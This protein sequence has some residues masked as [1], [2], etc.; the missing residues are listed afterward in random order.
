LAEKGTAQ[1]APDPFEEILERYGSLLRGTIAQVCPRDL[2]LQFD[3]IEQEARLRI[4]RTLKSETRIEKPASY[5]YRVA[6]TATLDAVRRAT[7]RREEQ[8]PPSSAGPDATARIEGQAPAGPPESPES[9]AHHRLL[10]DK[11]QAVLRGMRPDRRAAVSLHIRGFVP[12]EIGGLLRWSE[13]RA[14][15]AVYR[16][17]KE[18]RA[19]LAAEGIE[20]ES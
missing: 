1:G 9:A 10:L 7:A 11:V 2:G 15:S 19:R 20:Y 16:G 4:W 6:V 8:L 13:A 17:L 12:E 5:L 14:R 3:D 18:L